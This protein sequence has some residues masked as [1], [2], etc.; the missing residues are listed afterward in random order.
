MVERDE[1]ADGADD[2]L[3]ISM[4]ESAIEDLEKKLDISMEETNQHVEE[5]L[6]AQRDR[7]LWRGRAETAAGKIQALSVELQSHLQ[8]ELAELKGQKNE[9][10][11]RP[12]QPEPEWGGLDGIT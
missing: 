11:P 9:D 8:R 10:P 3:Y 6:T 4:L 1:S 12:Y 5:R 2:E 7:D